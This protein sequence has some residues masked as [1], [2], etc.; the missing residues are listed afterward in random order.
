MIRLRT[1]LAAL[2]FFIL[3]ASHLAA[4]ADSGSPDLFDEPPDESAGRKYYSLGVRAGP[5]LATLH[6][7]LRLPVVEISGGSA[8]LNAGFDDFDVV[9]YAEAFLTLRWVSIY[10][11]AYLA[12]FEDRIEA[13]SD[14]EFQGE[15]FRSD[16]PIHAKLDVLSAGGRLQVN[17][18]AFDWIELGV[19][20]GGRYFRLDGEIEQD[21]EGTRVREKRRVEFPIPQVGASLTLFL[22]S[23]LDIYARARGFEATWREF[24]VK[25]LEGELGLAF[26]LG[27][28]VSAGAEYRLFYA[29]IDDRRSHGATGGKDR[30]EFDATLHGPLAYVRVRF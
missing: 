16:E 26:N 24:A 18:L 19:S 15:E 28:H 9:P 2:I 1:L 21:F 14:F 5:W 22:G 17:P 3:G 6:G 13:H 7:T 12:H 20:L 4:Q 27:D 8:R 23:W 29:E 30:A 11:D 25:Q 10:A